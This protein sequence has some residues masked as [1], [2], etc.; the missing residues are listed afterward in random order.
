MHICCIFYFVF[1]RNC[2]CLRKGFELVERSKNIRDL[3]LGVH[4]YLNFKFKPRFVSSLNLLAVYSFKLYILFIPS[5]FVFF[6]WYVTMSSH[7]FKLQKCLHNI[8]SLTHW[9]LRSCSFVRS[10]LIFHRNGR[11]NQSQLENIRFFLLFCYFFSFYVTMQIIFFSMVR[12]SPFPSTDIASS[13]LMRLLLHHLQ[14]KK[15]SV[16]MNLLIL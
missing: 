14:K 2:F 11:L 5:F 12:L 7:S 9:R 4:C 13:V 16:I 10:C 6:I 15:I 3:M 1:F 8:F